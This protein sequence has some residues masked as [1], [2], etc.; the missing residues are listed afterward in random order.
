MLDR[1]QDWPAY[2]AAGRQFVEQVRNWRN[3]VANYAPV[4]RR[5]PGAGKP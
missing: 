1:R 3:S 5:L 4:Y 2:R